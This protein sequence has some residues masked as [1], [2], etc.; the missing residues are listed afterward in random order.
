MANVYKR[1]DRWWVR[2][3]IN[4]TEVRKPAKTTIKA[5][6]QAYLNQLLE[7]E[8]RLLRGG[9]P[10][11]TVDEL[12]SRFETDHVPTLRSAN[13]YLIAIRTFRPHL[14]SIVLD[15]LSKQ[16]LIGFITNRQKDGLKSGSIKREMVVLGS[17][18]S[19]AVNIG[20]LNINPM[21]LLDRRI[22]KS[23]PSRRRYLNHDEERRLLEAASPH[24]R[25]LIVFAIETG[26]RRG[27][28]LS[29]TWDQVDL[30]RREL[31]LFITKSDVPRIVPL[32]DRAL[33]VLNGL[34]RTTGCP[35]V[36]VNVRTGKRYF[37][38]K[39]GLAGQ[40]TGHPS[41][42]CDGMIYAGHV[43]VGSFRTIGPTSITSA[44]GS[45]MHQPR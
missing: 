4:G 12:L 37:S 1:G 17:A 42:T 15:Q 16:D 10:R 21:M 27:E 6:A 40:L 25:D 3:H 35:F 11:H 34:P 18:F 44:G 45:G 30:V 28:Q 39:K 20:W 41:P 2:Y 24:V 31:K 5:T 9:I 33:K 36:F 13:T 22:L 38:P 32:S 14:G 23:S 29:L 26:L 19:F 8:G 43:A 7:E